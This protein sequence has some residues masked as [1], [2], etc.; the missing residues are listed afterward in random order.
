MLT[1]KL[2]LRFLDKYH[3]SEEHSNR[4]SIKYWLNYIQLANSVGELTDWTVVIS[5]KNRDEFPD[6]IGEYLIPQ[7]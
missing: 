5:S 6:K 4:I 2:S 7:N 1:L 3:E